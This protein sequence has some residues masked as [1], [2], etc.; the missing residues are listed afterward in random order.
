VDRFLESW[1]EALLKRYSDLF[2]TLIG[3]PDVRV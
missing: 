2:P 3:E 1:G